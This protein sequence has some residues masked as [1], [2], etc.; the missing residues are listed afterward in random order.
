M[1]Q[2]FSLFVLRREED[3]TGV[4]G[5]GIVAYGVQFP[6]GTVALRWGGE[7]P[8]TVVHESMD[9]VRA[10]HCHNGKTQVV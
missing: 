1:Q 10:I 2:A 5:V 8:S 7:R 3:V 6:D 9:N 4:S